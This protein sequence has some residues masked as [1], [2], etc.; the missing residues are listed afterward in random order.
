MSCVNIAR[1]ATRSRGGGPSAPDEGIRAGKILPGH[2]VLMG[3][4]GGGIAWG[5]ALVRL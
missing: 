5:S 4:L 3:A 2:L 1:V